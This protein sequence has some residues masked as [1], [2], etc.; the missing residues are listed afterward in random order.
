MVIV[1]AVKEFAGRSLGI[2]NLV[3]HVYYFT[4]EWRLGF[5]R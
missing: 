3:S 5:L 4:G 2:K 1:A